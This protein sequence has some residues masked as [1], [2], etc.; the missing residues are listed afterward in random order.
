VQY[1]YDWQMRANGG[2]ASGSGGLDLS[3]WHGNDLVTNVVWYRLWSDSVS[4]GASDGGIDAGTAWPP[5]Y[6][7]S[8]DM[9]ADEWYVVNVGAWVNCDASGPPFINGATYGIVN[10]HLRWLTVERL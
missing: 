2:S 10:A 6:L 1:D 5:D 7:I 9:R 4:W 3:G 8:M